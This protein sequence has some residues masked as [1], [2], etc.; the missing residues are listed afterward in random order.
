M[1]GVLEDA[2]VETL[3]PEPGQTIVLTVPKT[4]GGDLLQAAGEQL[5]DAFPDNPVVVLQEDMSLSAED[6][7]MVATITREEAE[8]VLRPHDFSLQDAD[9]RLYRKLCDALDAINKAE[10]KR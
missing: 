3:A 10:G 7:P 6:D 9:V 1:S 8:S 2:V 5:K 4:L